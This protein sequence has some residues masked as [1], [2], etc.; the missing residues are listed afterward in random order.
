MPISGL[1]GELAHQGYE[2][3]CF[4]PGRPIAKSAAVTIASGTSVLLGMQPPPPDDAHAPTVAS[5]HCVL[6][7]LSARIINAD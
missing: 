3:S 4:T 6:S 5:G 7:I 1:S 2:I